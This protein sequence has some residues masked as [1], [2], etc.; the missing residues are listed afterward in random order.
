MT[1]AGYMS[2]TEELVKASCP[3]FQDD[4][5]A[6]Y[7]LSVRSPLPP[8][9]STLDLPGEQTQVIYVC[10]IKRIDQHPVESDEDRAP[11]SISDNEN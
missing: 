6:A 2:N 5:V 4:G 10:Q 8:A 9:L 3:L 1:T 11:D 7:K